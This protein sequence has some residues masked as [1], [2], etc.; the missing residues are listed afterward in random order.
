MFKIFIMSIPNWKCVWI[1]RQNHKKYLFK[2]S[3]MSIKNRQNITYFESLDHGSVQ[4]IYTIFELRD[5][6][7]IF[8][9]IT[10]TV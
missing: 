4:C 2:R 3:S 8:Y 1:F 6:E 7:L 9:K 5:F 10:L